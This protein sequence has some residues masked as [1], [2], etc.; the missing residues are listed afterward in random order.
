MPSGQSTRRL[1][2]ASQIVENQW[3]QRGGDSGFGSDG[4][5]YAAIGDGQAADGG[6]ANAV[7]A[8][9]PQTLQV[10]DWFPQPGADFVSTPVVFQSKGK[11]LLAEAAGDGRIFLLD[12]ASLGGADHKTPLAMTPP[13]SGAHE[14]CARCARELGGRERRALAA[15]AVRLA[16]ALRLVSRRRTAR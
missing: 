4:T 9:D 12:A 8:L 6:Y 1:R 14:C 2:T 13:S 5:I 16:V 15:G 11:E 10:K 7:V 3:R